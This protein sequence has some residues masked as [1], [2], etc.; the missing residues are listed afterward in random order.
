MVAP[1]AKQTL[2]KLVERIYCF[3]YFCIIFLTRTR[4]FVNMLIIYQNLEN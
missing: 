3:S 4:K 1:F 2:E